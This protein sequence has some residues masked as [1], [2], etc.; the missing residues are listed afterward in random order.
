MSGTVVTQETI[1]PPFISCILGLS[2][3]PNLLRERIS[4]RVR[5]RLDTGAID[6]TAH[7]L[8]VLQEHL[9]QKEAHRKLASFGLGTVIILQYLN[10][11]LTQSQLISQYVAKEYQYAKRQITWFKRNPEIH[12]IDS[13]DD[14][15]T[16]KSLELIDQFL[17]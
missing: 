7:L 12:W 13:S 10:G 2:L 11:S 16:N 14:S 8:E 6:E 9:T 15:L 3:S 4:T 17:N 5:E 1:K